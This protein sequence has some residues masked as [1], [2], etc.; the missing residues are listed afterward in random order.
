MAPRSSHDVPKN[1]RG[2]FD[3][4][5]PDGSIII[6]VPS[7]YSF[8]TSG[9]NVES[10]GLGR[11]LAEGLRKNEPLYWTVRSNF[12]GPRIDQFYCDRIDNPRQRYHCITISVR[13]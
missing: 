9:A 10:T 1:Q 8:I 13:V 4:Q 2:K 11:L 7:G 3:S 5:R 6:N 12:E